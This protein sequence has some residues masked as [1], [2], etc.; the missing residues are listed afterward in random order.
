MKS[1]VSLT[2]K[3]LEISKLVKAALREDIPAGD[4]TSKPLHCDKK[5][6][7]ARL[8]AKEDLVLSGCEIFELVFK[9]VSPKTKMTWKCFDGKKIRKGTV[10][11]L[12]KGD[13]QSLL[14]AERTAL[15][16][17]GHLSGIATL[18][19]RFSAQMSG[20]KTKIIDTRKTTP[21]LRALEKKAVVDGGGANHRLSLSDQVLL[22][23]NHIRAAG[24]ITKAVKLVR[25]EYPLKFIEVEITNLKELKEVL[26]ISSELTVNRV[27]L[28]NMSLIEM[29]KAVTLIDGRLEIE[30][31]GNMSVD[32][33][34]AVAK[35]GVDFISV[36]KL[37]HSAA[38]ADLS[39]LFKK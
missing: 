33:V 14:M 3:I 11:A 39:L 36:G 1:N 19:N 12:I 28:D 17:L 32:R 2:D 20:T 38:V 13:L 27:M 35:L 7:E 26:K 31:S 29:K 23:E 18:T 34:R 24:S 8:V 22:K 16:F 21:L 4:I 25:A 37:T 5:K 15:N 30:A 10:V 9:T 6:G